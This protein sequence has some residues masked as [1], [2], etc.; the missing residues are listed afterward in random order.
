[1]PAELVIYI[2]EQ[3]QK[4]PLADFN[5]IGR[6]KDVAIQLLDAGVSREHSSIRRDSSGYW[7][8][9]LGSANGT[10]VNDLAVT[11]SQ[12]LKNGDPSTK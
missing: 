8:N 7:V 9:D 2:G 1:M 5:I 4:F 10:Y 3:E 6:S 12:K 11:S